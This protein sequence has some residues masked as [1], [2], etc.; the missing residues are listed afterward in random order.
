MTPEDVAA[1]AR[2]GAAERGI[3]FYFRD[4]LN[5]PGDIAVSTGNK[6]MNCPPRAL[7]VFKPTEL[8][9]LAIGTHHDMQA[10]CVQNWTVQLSPTP[11]CEALLASVRRCLDAAIACC[12]VGERVSHI[13]AA[14]EDAGRREGIHLSTHFAGSLIGT[15]PHMAPQ[16]V[17][18][19]GLLK[20]DHTLSA[21]TMLSV[22]ALGHAGKPKL[23]TAD[24]GWT[25]RDTAGQLSAAFSHVVAV[26]DNGPLVL[27][28][29]HPTTIAAPA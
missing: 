16:I 15:E 26:T 10:F 6:V 2:Q 14:L 1:L 27:T 22:F 13:A 18:P 17:R 11:G 4:K 3:E 24:D 29:T 25:V 12:R 19:R 28:A 23:R 7:P 9:G 21:G 20:T 5:F 8:I